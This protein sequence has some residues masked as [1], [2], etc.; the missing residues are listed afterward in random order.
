[1]VQAKTENQTITSIVQNAETIRLV[2]K[3]GTKSVTDLKKGDEVMV[4][5]QEGGRHFG[6][7][8]KDERVI[9]R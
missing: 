8:V 1:M 7:L 9:E 4:F 6:K 3:D 5:I 2:T